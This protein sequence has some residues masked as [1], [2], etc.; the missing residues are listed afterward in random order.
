MNV[1]L[2]PLKKIIKLIHTGYD[3]DED[4]CVVY[5]MQ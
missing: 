3:D 4:L 2:L 5:K 1:S